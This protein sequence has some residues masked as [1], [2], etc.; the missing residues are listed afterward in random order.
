MNETKKLYRLDH[1][2]LAG[3]C[4]GVAEYFGIDSTIIR[5][6][7]AVFGL[8]YFTGVIAYL[9]AALVIPREPV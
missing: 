5:V 3:V 1:G 8:V 2:A 9:I 4:G 7:W 6:I